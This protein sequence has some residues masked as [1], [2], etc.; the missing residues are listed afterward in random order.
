MLLSVDINIYICTNKN[1]CFI[2]IKI[3]WYKSYFCAIFVQS[4]S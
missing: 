2:I 3:F 4:Y 1:V